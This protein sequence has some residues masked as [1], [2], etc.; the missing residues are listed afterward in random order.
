MARSAKRQLI[1]QEKTLAAPLAAEDSR[2]IGLFQQAYVL[3]SKHFEK[4]VAEEER[5]KAQLWKRGCL[6]CAAL[7][8]MAVAAVMG[9]TPLKQIVP[10]MALVNETTGATTV[11]Q[12]GG[13]HVS[14]EFAQDMY[15][16]NLYVLVRE[17]YNYAAQDD[18]MVLVKAMSDSGTYNEY[19]NFQLSSKGY[20]EQLGK[21]G[22][23]KT[24]L[25]NLI[26]VKS[27]E[28][29]NQRSAQA[30]FTRTVVDENGMPIL[31]LVP[32]KWQALITYR[33][34]KPSKDLKQFTLNPREFRVSSYQTFQQL[35]GGK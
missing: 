24:T 18:S 32:T 23:V 8:I 35:G 29:S 16:L 26:P 31:S 6:F 25:E 21:K 10:Y 28:G 34:D 2:F 20:L 3:A 12:P 22:Q 15:W 1:E 5:K 30:W 17:S 9:L 14:E 19:R 27:S 11:V 33:Y 4:Y 13:K 7:A